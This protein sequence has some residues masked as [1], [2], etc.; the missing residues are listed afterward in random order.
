MGAKRVRERFIR[1]KILLFSSY[2]IY[3]MTE[4]MKAYL[5]LNTNIYIGW[6]KS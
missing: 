5:I 4:N 1:K 3:D 2:N 6:R